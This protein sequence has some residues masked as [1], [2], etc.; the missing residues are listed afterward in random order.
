MPRHTPPSGMLPRSPASV[1]YWWDPSS[2]WHFFRQSVCLI[3]VVRQLVHALFILQDCF[4]AK[5]EWRNL[6]ADYRDPL[7]ALVDEFWDCFALCPHVASGTQ[8]TQE[9]RGGHVPGK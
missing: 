7:S 8:P 5:S 9:I 1:V 4:L 6:R 2:F 3:N